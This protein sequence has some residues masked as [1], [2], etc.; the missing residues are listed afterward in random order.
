[1]KNKIKFLL[2][3]SLANYLAAIIIIFPSGLIAHFIFGQSFS[4]YYIHLIGI[5]FIITKLIYSMLV[6]SYYSLRANSIHIPEF[7]LDLGV[8][9][10]AII[11]MYIEQK[12]KDAL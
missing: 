4:L 9:R 11:G 8:D 10:E 6:Y 5:S 2:F 7:M 12:A 1:M 3:K